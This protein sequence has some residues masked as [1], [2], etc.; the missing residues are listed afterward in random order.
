M[1]NNSSKLFKMLLKILSLPVILGEY[2]DSR[3]GKEYNVGFLKKVRLMLKMIKN[4]KKIVSASNYIEHVVMAARILNIPKNVEGCVIECGSYKGGSTANLSLVCSLCNRRLEI[5]DSFRGLPEISL[6]DKDHTCVGSQ[7]IHTYSKGDW[8]GT[9]NEVKKNISKYG[10]IRVCRFNEGYFKATLPQ[11]DRKSVFIFLDV[12]LKTS[13]LTCLKYLWPLLQENC[14]LYTHEAGDM[15]IASLF[16][17]KEWWFKTLKTNAPGLL[18]AGNGLGLNPQS[19]GFGSS[20]GYTIKNP[21][22][23]EFERIKWKK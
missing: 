10:D 9:L 13:L 4:N 12:D 6:D 5:F 15:G 3:T 18:G 14:S 2:F 20:I 16:F 19:G 21:K 11:F 7:E 17:D 1:K 8:I 22:I 23:Q